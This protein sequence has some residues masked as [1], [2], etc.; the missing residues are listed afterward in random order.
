MRRIL[1]DRARRKKTEKYGNG[2][3][4][5]DFDLMEIAAPADGDEILTVHDALDRPAMHDARKAENW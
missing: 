1:V 4:F 2:A 5:R 3:A